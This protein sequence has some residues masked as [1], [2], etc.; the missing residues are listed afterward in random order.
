[1]YNEVEANGFLL[2][3][4]CDANVSIH[5]SKLHDMNITYTQL[6]QIF[7]LRLQRLVFQLML[8]SIFMYLP[9]ILLNTR[10]TSQIFRQHI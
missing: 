5:I 6:M 2:I 7:N 9:L 4:K 10:D 3:P 1:M 8:N